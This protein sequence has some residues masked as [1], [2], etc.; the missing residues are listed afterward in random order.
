MLCSFTAWLEFIVAEGG[1]YFQEK[2]HCIHIK[3]LDYFNS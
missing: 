2:I 3:G 1:G